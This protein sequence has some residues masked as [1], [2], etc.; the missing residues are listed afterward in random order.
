M[1]T[2]YEEILEKLDSINESMEDTIKTCVSI[3]GKLDRIDKSLD[4]IE[5]DLDGTRSSLTY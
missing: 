2:N 4:N 5:N 1:K 3:N